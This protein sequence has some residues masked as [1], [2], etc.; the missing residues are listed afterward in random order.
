[1]NLVDMDNVER[2][3]DEKIEEIFTKA[4][5]STCQGSMQW[6]VWNS[7]SDTDNGND[8]EILADHQQFFGYVNRM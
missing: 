7:A 3:T 5:N 2:P 8:F 1:M 6:T 4:D